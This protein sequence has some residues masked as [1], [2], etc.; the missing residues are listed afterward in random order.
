MEQHPVMGCCGF[1][2]DIPT[3]ASPAFGL[4]RSPL[5]PHNTWLNYELYYGTDERLSFT[6]LAFLSLWWEEDVLKSHHP[7]QTL[8]C[9]GDALT[10]ATGGYDRAVVNNYDLADEYFEVEPVK[11]QEGGVARRS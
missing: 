2:S 1:L 4:N 7:S 8:N 6:G 9:P 5:G 3:E 11:L 10:M